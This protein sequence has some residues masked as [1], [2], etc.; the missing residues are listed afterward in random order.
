M[1][2]EIKNLREQLGVKESRVDCNVIL[3][4]EALV[5]SINLMNFGS[6]EESIMRLKSNNIADELI[7][8]LR[9]KGVWMM[10]V[11]KINDKK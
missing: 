4:Q 7:K 11:K 3:N 5:E 8:A 2:D 1:K 10:S 9:H 6:A